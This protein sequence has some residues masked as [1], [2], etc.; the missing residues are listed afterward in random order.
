MYYLG[1]PSKIQLKIYLPE[2]INSI[3]VVNKALIFTLNTDG[4]LSDVVIPTN[5]NLS[6]GIP[7]S[8]GIH[9]VTLENKGNY[10]NIT[11]T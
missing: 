10:V 1:A 6:G 8:A 3:V 7:V 9:F 4:G 5:I 2:R 11:S